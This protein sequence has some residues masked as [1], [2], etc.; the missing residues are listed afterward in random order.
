MYKTT[1]E[2]KTLPLIS[3]RYVVLKVS[4]VE[5]SHCIIW[6]AIISYSV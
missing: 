3:T 5:G 1:P 2:M 4:G 6:I